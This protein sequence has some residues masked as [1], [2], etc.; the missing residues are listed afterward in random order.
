VARAGT[1]MTDLVEAPPD[2]RRYRVV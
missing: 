1:Q 2:I